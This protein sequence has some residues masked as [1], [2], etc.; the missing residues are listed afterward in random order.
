MSDISDVCKFS[1]QRLYLTSDKN[2][3]IAYASRKRP[4]LI[5]AV[6][7]SQSRS[8]SKSRQTRATKKKLTRVVAEHYNARKGASNVD[9]KLSHVM[10]LRNFNNWI[11]SMLIRKYVDKIKRKKDR[12]A[13]KKAHSIVPVQ[14]NGQCQH[15]IK[16]LDL[17]CGKGGDLLK[18]EKSNVTHL[19]CVDIAEESVK[20]CN[21]RYVQMSKKREQYFTAEFIVH[22]CTKAGLAKKLIHKKKQFDIVSCQFALHYSFESRRQ[23]KNLLKNASRNLRSGGY[24][25]GT[26]PNESELLSRWYA[27]KENKY[28]NNIY[29]VEFYCEK[30]NPPFYG[31]KYHFY[32]K[33]A[34]NCPEFLVNSVTLQQLALKY[35]L[36]FIVF[37]SFSDYFD[38]MKEVG[39][40]LMY[41]MQVPYPPHH[42]DCN[43]R[44]SRKGCRT[45]SQAEWEV[46]T[47]YSVFV[48][49]KNKD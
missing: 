40:Q 23:V 28:G 15:K 24:F 20:E 6:T 2:T 11:K 45:L 41:K 44:N 49:Q 18:W 14:N 5:M 43:S 7:R 33:D 19:A 26:M 47:L 1:V 29:N 38:K 30:L 25:I 10:N 39:K 42:N 36:K 48:F 37:K 12:R 21:D 22:D 31:A 13:A 16:V 32:L 34:V 4:N 27:T 8:L 35:G 3:G 46:I 17:C 9:R